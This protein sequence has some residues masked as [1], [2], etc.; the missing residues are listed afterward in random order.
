MDL[1]C[2]V[3]GKRWDE[4]GCRVIHVSGITEEVEHFTCETCKEE[5]VV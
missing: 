2:R 4:D 1:V 3:C 5:E